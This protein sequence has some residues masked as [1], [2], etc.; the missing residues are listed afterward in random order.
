[1]TR[2]P[3]DTFA[4]L[5][6]GTPAPFVWAARSLPVFVAGQFLLAGQALFGGW[7]WAAHGTLGGLIALPVLAIAGYAA[8]V[9]R[10]NGFGWWAA[11]LVGLYLVQVALAASGPATLAFHPFNA[12]VLLTAA[13]VMLF[14]VERRLGRQGRGP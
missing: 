10:L 8:L 11:V 4:D 14:K 5:G 9:P 2:I 3:H 7:G 1:M 12:A 6:R 13:T